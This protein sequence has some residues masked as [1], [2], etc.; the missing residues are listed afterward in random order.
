MANKLA[1][2]LAKKGIPVVSDPSFYVDSKLPYI[3][4]GHFDPI[5]VSRIYNKIQN[6]IFIRNKRLFTI[7][8]KLLR[9][10]YSGKKT[11]GS[12]KLKIIPAPDASFSI[13][14]VNGGFKSS[15]P[16][17]LKNK[18]ITK[19]NK[20]IKPLK[21]KMADFVH[22]FS[23]FAS[24]LKGAG[25]HS[26]KGGN[27]VEKCADSIIRKSK[28]D[29]EVVH[30]FYEDDRESY[31]MLELCAKETKQE[32]KVVDSMSSAYLTRNEKVFN[33]VIKL[34][35]KHSSPDEITVGMPICVEG[36]NKLFKLLGIFAIYSPGYMFNDTPNADKHNRAFL[37]LAKQL[38]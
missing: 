7:V 35:G 27:P 32:Q 20:G 21:A 10:F 2:V 14:I 23:K 6:G 28:M 3:A 34:I 31:P 30:T 16:Y 13:R 18:I 37:E 36:Q 5:R 26:G 1:Q 25:S 12:I 17:V 38:S 11:P 33:K 8:N 22:E 29:I 9:K 19:N 24:F 4:I 15:R